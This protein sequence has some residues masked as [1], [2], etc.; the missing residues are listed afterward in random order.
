MNYK[1][2]CWLLIIVMWIQVA[3]MA[4]MNRQLMHVKEGFRKAQ[5]TWE[6]H[7][8][9]LEAEIQKLRLKK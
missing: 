2:L 5:S 8:Q 6:D 1:K 4:Q 3:V 7:R 9:E